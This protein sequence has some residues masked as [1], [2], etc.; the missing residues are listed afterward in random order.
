MFILDFFGPMMSQIR[1]NIALGIVLIAIPYIF[2]KK[3][4]KYELII[5]IAFLFHKTAIICT[6]FYFV[7]FCLFYKI[8]W[9]YPNYNVLW[10]PLNAEYRKDYA[11]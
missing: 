8:R 11:E 10:H 9:F 2:K 3:F 6:L 5:F 4:I 7:R 1:Q